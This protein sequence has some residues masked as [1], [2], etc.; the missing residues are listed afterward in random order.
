MVSHIVE[1]PILVRALSR[2]SVFADDRRLRRLLSA[3]LENH[4]R[5]EVV[6]NN[7]SLNQRPRDN[8]LEIVQRCQGVGQRSS[9]ALVLVLKGLEDYELIDDADLATL[10]SFTER[11]LSEAVIGI[12]QVSSSEPRLVRE[13]VSSTSELFVG[14]GSVSILNRVALVRAVQEETSKAKFSTGCL[15][16]TEWVLTSGHGV[17]EATPREVLLVFSEMDPVKKTPIRQEVLIPVFECFNPYEEDKEMDGALLH[18]DL[19]DTQIAEK[20]QRL[21]EISGEIERGYNAGGKDFRSMGYPTG[22]KYKTSEGDEGLDSYYFEGQIAQGGNSRRELLQLSVSSGGPQESEDWSGVSGAPVMVGSQLVGLVALHGQKFTQTLNAVSL[23]KLERNEAFKERLDEAWA[24]AKTAEAIVNGRGYDLELWLDGGVEHVHQL[25]I[26]AWLFRK[27]KK[28]TKPYT[29]S[30][31]EK[32]FCELPLD[33]SLHTTHRLVDALASLGPV[34]AKA[35]ARRLLFNLLPL[36]RDGPSNSDEIGFDFREALRLQAAID[37]Y[38]AKDKL[39]APKALRLDTGFGSETIAAIEGDQ[40]LSQYFVD[41]VAEEKGWTEQQAYEAIVGDIERYFDDV[42]YAMD[43]GLSTASIQRPFF[44]SV[45]EA[46]EA[47]QS[48]I[49]ALQRELKIG[50]YI[51]AGISTPPKIRSALGRALACLGYTETSGPESQT[52][53]SPT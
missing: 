36:H 19:R 30:E 43:L 15:I 13:A 46:N 20:V 11:L 17:H 9:N 8:A 4:P 21:A 3:V 35:Q 42:E 28:G 12:P 18:L 53:D 26:R 50:V 23:E 41:L 44:I 6:L 14:Y 39:I 27:A 51:D 47:Q 34:E 2:M 7:L 29:R 52:Q 31:V 16:G 5:S 37:L 22:G 25:A 38:R 33:K 49:K 48:I 1:T 24:S 32:R 40:G 45:S 10:R